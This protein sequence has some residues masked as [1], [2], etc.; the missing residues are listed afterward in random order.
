[1]LGVLG[2]FAITAISI[3]IWAKRKDKQEHKEKNL[4]L[5][6][7]I[8][9]LEIKVEQT[10]EDLL[11]LEE[12]KKEKIEL[13]KSGKEKYEEKKSIEVKQKLKDLEVEQKEKERIS[14]LYK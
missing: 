9:D 4:I 5:D 1:M 6:K 8:H 10:K 3:F 11:K 2:A 12:L 13:N 7:K 14:N